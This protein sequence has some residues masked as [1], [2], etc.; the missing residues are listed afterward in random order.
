[1]EGIGRV[2]LIEQAWALRRELVRSTRWGGFAS[3]TL[4]GCPTRKYH[5]WF[6]LWRD[7]GRVE[8]LPQIQEELHLREGRFLLTTQYF[9]RKLEWEGYRH[10]ESFQ[11]GP[12]WK[13]TFRFGEIAVEKEVYMAPDVP[14]W[15]LRYRFSGPLLF[16]WI[17]LWAVRP[18]HTLRHEP[19][20][21]ARKGEEIHFSEGICLRFRVDPV[22][23]F[24]PWEYVYEG[25]YY[26]EEELR[27]Y[28]AQEN[29]YAHECWEWRFHQP[30]EI[31]IAFSP[32]DLSQL[33]LPLPKERKL[34]SFRDRL[35]EAAEN[36]FLETADGSYVIAGH[37]WF[38]VWGRD[39]FISLPGLTL[40]RGE[41]NRFHQ[42]I[43][44][45][46][47]YV[48]PE[49]TFPNIFPDSYTAEDTGLWWIWALMQYAR[50]GGSEKEIWKRY[51]EAL[52]FVVVGYL[53]RLMGEDGLLRVASFPPASWM[54]AV[55]E[56]HPAVL[57]KGALV[58][59]NALWYAAL[60]FLADIAQEEGVRW[61]WTL[62]ARQV[63]ERFKPTFWDKSRGYLADW[64]DTTEVSWSIRPNQLFAAGLYYRPISD[65][66]AELILNTVERHLLTPRGLRTLSPS[67]PA[68]KGHCEG[69]QALR[70]V[71]YHNGTVWPWLLGTY[72]EAKIT[73][74]GATARPYLEK[75]LRD[76]ESALYEYGWEMLPE[77]YDGDAP[78]LPRGAPA[79]A[80]SIAELLRIYS[81]LDLL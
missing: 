57:R 18:W 78:H 34:V 39:T 52:Q 24:V 11:A 71:A 53:Q 5:S 27:G 38:G 12:V 22:P 62:L 9:H 49:G 2:P 60:R 3:T 68:Y 80:W 79:Q 63:L 10:L 17:P 36:F 77:I 59:I 8:L 14:L 35:Y 23:R 42:V 6:S 32:D 64:R 74:W 56:G 4:W 26:P 66:I 46:L 69:A 61:R 41:E 50:W 19:L 55:V 48:S 76:F 1:M 54:D 16:R 65:K 75:I 40:A 33:S 7:F 73:L 20:Q 43:E 45:S 72:A 30:G 67:D 31:R 13:W 37:P 44:T 29:L 25:V 70:D 21:I 47:R 15:M 28:P 58:E 81:L 51:G